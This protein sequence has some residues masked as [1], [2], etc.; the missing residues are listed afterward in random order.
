LTNKK[1]S[2]ASIIIPLRDPTIQIPQASYRGLSSPLVGI[3]SILTRL[4]LPHVGE[5]RKLHVRAVALANAV[6]T[7]AIAIACHPAPRASVC[8]GV[9]VLT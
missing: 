6:A 2:N 9:C 1:I 3:V 7:A 4:F 8:V 5:I